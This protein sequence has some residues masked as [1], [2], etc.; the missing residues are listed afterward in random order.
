MGAFYAKEQQRLCRIRMIA[1]SVM[2]E[3]LGY[4]KDTERSLEGWWLLKKPL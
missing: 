2:M 1:E 3:Q 4:L